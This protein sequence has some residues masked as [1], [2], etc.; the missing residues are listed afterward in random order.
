MDA[1]VNCTAIG[2]PVNC[3]GQYVSPEEEYFK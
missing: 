3:T 2:L 1:T